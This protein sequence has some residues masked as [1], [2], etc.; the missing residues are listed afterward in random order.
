MSVDLLQARRWGLAASEP[1]GYHGNQCLTMLAKAVRREKA[2]RNWW[3]DRMV[4]AAFLP[5][6][7][8]LA[9]VRSTRARPPV[10]N[11]DLGGYALW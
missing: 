3:H 10:P 9:L 5:H 4:W 8:G 11:L 6:V 7:P 2:Q 1:L